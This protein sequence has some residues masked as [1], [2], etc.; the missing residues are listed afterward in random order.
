MAQ[1][2]LVDEGLEGVQ[3]G[4]GDFL[5]GLQRA[6]TGEDGQ[7]GEQLLLLV[8]EELVAPLDRR[9]QRLLARIGVPASLEQFA[10][11]REPLQDLFGGEGAR[12]GCGQFDRQRQVVEAAA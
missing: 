1:Q 11:L 4:I 5:R 9:P 8:R 6:A 12:P 7:T 10:A 2:A 3:I